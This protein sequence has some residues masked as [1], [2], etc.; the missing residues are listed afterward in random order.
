[1]QATTP[2]VR[3]LRPLRYEINLDEASTTIT[4]LL[5]EEVEK[6]TKVFG[7][8]EMMKSKIDME[9]KTTSKINKKD[10]LVKKLKAKF[11]EG[12][13]EGEEDDE[14]EYEEEGE[15]DQGPLA[16]TQGMGEDMEEEGVEEEEAEEAPIKPQP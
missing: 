15:Q 14:E 5:A 11:G 12:T 16:L 4:T 7:N 8:Y 2:R 13:T 9:L 6:T 1:M 3:W 10:R